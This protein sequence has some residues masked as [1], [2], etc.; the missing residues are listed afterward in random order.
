VGR[1]SI[2][3][4]Q[5]EKPGYLGYMVLASGAKLNEYVLGKR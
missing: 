3:S 2:L 4:L 1:P 5:R